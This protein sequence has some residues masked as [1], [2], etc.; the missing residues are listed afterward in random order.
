MSSLDRIPPNVYKETIENPTNNESEV[1]ELISTF[2]MIFMEY[3]RLNQGKVGGDNR[4]SIMSP[5]FR[6]TDPYR[7]VIDTAV[8]RFYWRLIQ[9]GYDCVRE[10]CVP[11]KPNKYSIKMIIDLT[12]INE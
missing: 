6:L 4:Y 10:V 3:R 7:I 2:V 1:E 12:P 5:I 9:Q 11:G 8:A